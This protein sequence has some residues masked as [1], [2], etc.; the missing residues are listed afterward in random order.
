MRPRCLPPLAVVGGS[1]VPRGADALSVGLGDQEGFLA[2]GEHPV[3]G[4]VHRP[5]AGG[6]P[7]LL[8]VVGRGIG[9]QEAV[10]HV[11][12]RVAG[13]DV[14]PGGQLV[15]LNSLAGVRDAGGD[16]LLGADVLAH[17]VRLPADE[18]GDLAG[19][20]LPPGDVVLRLDVAV[21][22]P[23]VCPRRQA[24]GPIRQ[25]PL[26]VEGL[27]V[28]VLVAQMV[29]EA[30]EDTLVVEEMQAR[31]VV[32]L[33]A[34]DRRVVGVPGDHLADDPLG[35]EAEGWVGEVHLLAGAPAEALSGGV[36]PG[37]LRVL[38]G[39]PRRHRV[40]RCAD[41]DGDAALVGAVEDRLEPVEVEAPVVRL[42]G[43]PDRFADPDH[44]EVRRGHQVE[45]G[46]ELFVG[47]QFGIVR[48]RVL[49]VVRGAEQDAG[50]QFRHV[51]TSRKVGGVT[52]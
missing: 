52:A 24:V 30:L 12:V 18:L 46:L 33:P 7:D 2:G 22:R 48:G 40:R 45:V 34:D 25:A 27:D 32:D 51:A 1:V 39:Q 50:G 19:L 6:L 17:D 38:T 37:D 41:D 28:P 49:V 23:Q 29:D 14:E 9:E 35:V 47:P 36:L 4:L 8:V 10:L 44:G 43:R 16:E 13:G 3:R 11:V 31:L 20:E 21:G 26:A 5:D 15:V 42:P